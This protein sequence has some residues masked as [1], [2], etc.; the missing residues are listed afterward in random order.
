MRY[1]YTVE[2]TVDE[3]DFSATEAE[4]LRAALR[5]VAEEYAT[6]EVKVLCEDGWC[7]EKNDARIRA[8]LL[9]MMKGVRENYTPRDDHQ[10]D[11]ERLR[12]AHQKDVEA[13]R[14]EMKEMRTEMR[15]EIRQMS[16]DVKDIK[17]NCI[18]REEFVS[19]QLKLENKLDR[20]MEFMMKQGGN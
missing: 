8:A 7:I 11:L 17:E 13:L 19:H 6:G 10:K 2:L 15:T 1:R 9:N 18:R 4:H 3:L 16:D 12:T 14:R 20:L 5:E